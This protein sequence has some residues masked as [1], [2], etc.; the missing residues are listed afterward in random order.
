MTSFAAPAGLDELL[1]E[2]GYHRFDHSLV[3]SKD[4]KS[5]SDSFSPNPHLESR[6]VEHWLDEYV[7]LSRSPMSRR[8]AHLA[9]LERI[10]GN[11][12]FG[13]LIPDGSENPVAAGLA[14][15]EGDYIGLF[16]I[17]T[18]PDHRNR[19]H[20]AAL[21]NALLASAVAT[22][23]K[24]AYLQVVSENSAAIALYRKLGFSEAYHYWYRIPP[25][26]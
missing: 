14:V 11:A 12:L 13:V 18:D 25:D 3:L 10:P 6:E 22:G 23:A 24:T 2:R 7:R 16:D 8:D 20:G 21:V 5:D 19:G 1:D 26:R 4:L 17:V 15:T 9:I